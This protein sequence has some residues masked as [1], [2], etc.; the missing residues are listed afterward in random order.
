MNKK[1]NDWKELVK[2]FVEHK[3]ILSSDLGEKNEAALQQINNKEAAKPIRN[4]R[5]GNIR[6][7]AKNSPEVKHR[8]S[9]NIIQGNESTAEELVKKM[10]GIRQEEAKTH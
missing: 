10:K 4:P 3:D 5:L 2:F 8:G 6:R 7:K 1:G 9:R